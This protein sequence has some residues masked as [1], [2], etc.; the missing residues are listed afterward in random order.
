V[1]LYLLMRYVLPDLV[2][3]MARSQE[4]LLIFAIAWGTGLAALGEY[5]GFSKEAGAFVAGFSLASTA[6]REAMNAR[7]TGIRDFMLLFFFIDLGGKLDFSTLGNEILPAIVL[8]LFV[9]I[10]NPLIVMAIQPCLPARAQACWFQR[11]DRW[12]GARRPAWQGA[13]CR[14]SQPG[15]QSFHRC[16]GL[17]RR[18][19]LDELSPASKPNPK[20]AVD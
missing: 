18:R 12:R 17:R 5:S 11:E 7:L 15:T 2:S 6:Y 4:L 8:A 14:G 16:R 9:L 3:R 1:L 20:P 13:G 19:L 10:G